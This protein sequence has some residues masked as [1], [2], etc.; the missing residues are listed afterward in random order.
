MCLISATISEKLELLVFKECILP[1]NESAQIRGNF[2]PFDLGMIHS[3]ATTM[4]KIGPLHLLM[5]IP[6]FDP[7]VLFLKEASIS[8]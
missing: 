6:D 8:M 2:F 7:T 5:R 4:I 3:S 1:Q